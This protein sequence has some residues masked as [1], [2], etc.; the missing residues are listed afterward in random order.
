[1]AITITQHTSGFPE[2]S[3]SDTVV[4]CTGV[5]AGGYLVV[6]TANQSD[7]RTYT[8]ASDLDGAFTAVVGVPPDSLT[9]R[10][11]RAY[12]LRISTAGTHSV[13]IHQLLTHNAY[14][15]A[16][17]E[18][19]ECAVGYTFS[20]LSVTDSAGPYY[21]AV[22][23]GLS[24]PAGGA[25]IAGGTSN[26]SRHPWDTTDANYAVSNGASPQYCAHFTQVFA[27]ASAAERC[28][29][30]TSSPIATDD[31][32]GLMVVFSPVGGAPVATFATNI[33]ELQVGGSTF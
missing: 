3:A 4:S 26:A 31:H 12:V 6:L 2:S 1:M 19:T 20:S 11:L 18:V 28:A 5:A 10:Y 9:T 22:E 33:G 32:G 15:Y 23:G 24:V 7:T 8:V 27:S 17:F 13:T 30:T 29:Y 14:R 16:V 21:C 25:V